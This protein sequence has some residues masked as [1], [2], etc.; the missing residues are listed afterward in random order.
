MITHY[1]YRTYNGHVIRINDS[2]ALLKRCVIRHPMTSLDHEEGNILFRLFSPSV[3]PRT[4]II[5]LDQVVKIDGE[6][7][8]STK[9]FEALK[10]E[11]DLYPE[12]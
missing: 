10:K 5:W 3:T 11:L 4:E 12:L 2:G 1:K 9:T 6:L 7:I 8:M